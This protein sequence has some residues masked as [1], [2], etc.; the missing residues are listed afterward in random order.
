MQINLKA[1]N[2]W[3]FALKILVALGALAFVF[4]KVYNQGLEPIS[5][6]F[7]SVNSLTFFIKLFQ[8]VM[9]MPISWTVEAIK[10]KY[11]LKDFSPIGFTASFRMIWYGVGVG[12]LTPN[13]IGEPFGRMIMI[14]QQHRV[15]GGAMAILCGM[16]Q[17]AAT[18]IFGIIGI[19]YLGFV[20]KL[21]L[22]IGLLNPWVISV[23]VIFTIISLSIIIGVE[24]ITSLAKRLKFIKRFIL[25]EEVLAEKISATKKI[26]LVLLSIA[27]YLVFSTQLVILLSAFGLEVNLLTSY[28]AV[29]ATYLLAS[30][31]PSFA[32]AEFGIRASFAIVIVGAFW[33]NALGIAAATTTLWLLNVAMPGV[34][35]VILPLLPRNSI[36]YAKKHHPPI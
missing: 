7:S 5:Q 19:Y 29:F 34:V 31:V 14:P 24:H 3:W 16:S 10:W 35:G 11:A 1:N 18:I 27:R 6:S 33:E 28:A 12:L 8:A 20:V 25:N 17:Q 26:K 23:A 13:R 2:T 36:E 32:L 9:L 30:L 21:D 22:L 4:F 15:Q